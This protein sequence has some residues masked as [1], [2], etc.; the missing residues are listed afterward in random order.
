MIFKNCIGGFEYKANT[1][2]IIN[3]LSPRE[4]KVHKPNG[5]EIEKVYPYFIV[6]MVAENFPLSEKHYTYSNKE[7]YLAKVEECISDMRALGFSVSSI[8]PSFLLGRPFVKIDFEHD[9]TK[10]LAEQEKEEVRKQRERGEKGYI[11]FG[12]IPESGKSY[13]YRDNF[14]EEG[15]SAYHAV[16]FP[17]GSY[18]ILQHNPFELFGA[19][20]YSNR[21]AYRL[22][23]EELGTGSDGEPVLKVT[24]SIKLEKNKAN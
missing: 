5:V 19:H 3:G 17:D 6:G 18:E 10:T 13:N 20:L 15:V 12:D 8:R 7:E 4:I 16:F 23:G 24:Q 22:Y 2:V 1:S 14:Y 21:P 9:E 11:R